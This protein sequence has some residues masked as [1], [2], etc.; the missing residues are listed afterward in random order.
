MKTD[1]LGK[2]LLS[3]VE[4][5]ILLLVMSIACTSIASADT[6]TVTKT[7]DTNGICLSGNCSLREAIAAANS[8]TANDTINFNIPT[9]DPGCSG[10]VCT[11]RG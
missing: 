8:S 10:G 9:S 7:A 1:R 11:I 6:Y 2:I 3:K 4:R 5:M